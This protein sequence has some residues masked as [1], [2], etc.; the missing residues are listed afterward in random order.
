M[1]VI[2]MCKLSLIAHSADRS[3]IL[4][5][6]VKLGV[7]ETVRSKQL[8]HTKYQANPSGEAKYNSLLS[9]LSF[10][11]TFFKERNQ[12]AL[13]QQI[14]IP[15]PL[16]LTKINRL[17]DAEEL[18]L[19]GKNEYDL[20]QKVEEIEE[21]NSALVDNI[22]R[23]SRLAS[24]KEQ[25]LFYQDLD[26]KFSEIKDSKYTCLKVGSLPATGAEKLTGKDSFPG[27][28]ITRS[29]STRT[30]LTA[31]IFHKSNEQAALNAL[32]QADFMPCPFAED[33]FANKEIERIEAE[34]KDCERAAADITQKAVSMFSLAEKFKILYDYYLIEQKKIEVMTNATGSGSTFLLEGWVPVPDQEKVKKGILS[35]TSNIYME[36]R[37]PLESESPPVYVKSNK[38]IAP[39][40]SITNMYGHPDPKADSDPNLFVAIFYF[41][42]FG[43]M[44]GDAGYGII[45]ALAC[46]AF[47]LIKKPK[48]SSG[49]MILVFGF[50]GIS[51]FIWGIIFGGWFGIDAEVLQANAFGRFLL[52]LSWFNPL[53]EPLMMFGLALALGAIQIAVGFAINAYNRWK[54]SKADA[55]L[56]NASWVVILLGIGIIAIGAVASLPILNT[57][58]MASAG[59]GVG[60]LVLGGTIGKKGIIKK[61]TGSLGNVYGGINVF[62]DILSYSRLF[63]L[64]LTTGVIAMVINYLGDII[65]QII[66]NFL[67]YIG[68][69]VILIFGH[70]FNLGINLLGTYVHNSRLQYIEFFSKFYQ[71]T[72]KPFTP[73]GSQTK[74][75]FLDN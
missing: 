7:V 56:N 46:F 69:I 71:G 53:D 65:I 58:G 17:L 4:R 29:T 63:G 6:L 23:A 22:A 61:V 39:F 62:S 47:Y 13:K 67:G 27:I 41:L 33:I 3:K 12:Y 21:L 32:A 48:K 43:I 38:V 11:F 5:Q 51:T 42:F 9:R 74:Y 55:I 57:I 24:R 44:M 37:S 20:L 45:I 72:G 60:M 26:I 68:A 34:L 49:H 1:A 36:F 10:V 52:K 70:T 16:N 31:A 19:A 59:V 75:I 14:E 15:V 25:L 50:C 73:L 54:H 2:D 8:E 35:V 30:L 18:E 28:L 66:P 40:Q 64:G